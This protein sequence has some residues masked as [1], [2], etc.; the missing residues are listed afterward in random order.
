MTADRR[1]YPIQCAGSAGRTGPVPGLVSGGDVS[2]FGKM[3]DFGVR[4]MRR[5]RLGSNGQE[6]ALKRAA[7]RVSPANRTLRRPWPGDSTHLADVDGCGGIQPSISAGPFPN[8]GMMSQERG[9]T[10]LVH[11][12]LEF[13]DRNRVDERWM[14]NDV[15]PPRYRREALLAASS[16][17]P[18]WDEPLARADRRKARSS[19]CR[20]LARASCLSTPCRCYSGVSVV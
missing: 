12:W 19:P 4:A 1:P 5:L 15:F 14:K 13:P 20:T 17:H 9:Q 10:R 18:L 11:S 7:P 3:D 6:K 16:S 8:S 2:L